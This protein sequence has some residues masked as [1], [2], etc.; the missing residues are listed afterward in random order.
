MR[1]PASEKLEIIQL[2]EQSLL[3]VRRTLEKVGIPRVTFYRWYDLLPPVGSDNLT[4]RPSIK[5]GQALQYCSFR[6][7]CGLSSK[8]PK[9]RSRSSF[10]SEGVAIDVQ[11][12][13]GRGPQ[14]LR[15]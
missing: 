12:P 2:V 5:I 11:V 4:D 13:Q 10:R 7:S 1:Y 14:L 15:R 9:R 6:G 3:A 8:R